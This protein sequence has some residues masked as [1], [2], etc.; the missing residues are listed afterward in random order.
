LIS[1]MLSAACHAN[2]G[3]ASARVFLPFLIKHLPEY[4]ISQPKN[5]ASFLAQCAHESGGFKRIT[6]NLNYSALGLASTWPK[7][8]ANPDKMPNQLA[9]SLGRNPKAIADN[10]YANRMGN[11]DEASGE[12]WKYRGRGIIQLTGKDN[13]SLLAKESGIDCLDNPDILME[14]ENAVIAAC[15]FWKKYKIG[16]AKDF[17]AQTKLINGGTHG[18]DDRKARFNSALAVISEKSY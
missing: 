18:L 2:E 16:E 17:I 11:G 6:E 4:G 5:V 8:Y 7:R 9:L 13:Y 14:P 1:D 12:G 15:W 3:T 10:V